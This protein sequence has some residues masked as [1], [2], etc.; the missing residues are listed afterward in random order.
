MVVQT[1]SVYSY[2]K[3]KQKMREEGRVDDLSVSGVI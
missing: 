1:E 2:I 3:P